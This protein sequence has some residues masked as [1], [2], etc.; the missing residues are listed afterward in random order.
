MVLSAFLEMLGIGIVFPILNLLV[1]GRDSFQNL[2]VNS[3]YSETPAS[4]INN[5]SDHE[6][7]S[8]FLIVLIF[9]FIFKTFFFIFLY[10]KNSS[11]AFNLEKDL[12]RKIFIKR[13]L[14]KCIW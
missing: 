12:S 5:L 2:F 13:N 14:Y 10:W 9:I 1:E 4:Y 7:I 6:L 11:L 3:G 8:F